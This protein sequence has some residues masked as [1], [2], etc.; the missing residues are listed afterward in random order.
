MKLVKCNQQSKEKGEL[1]K[2]VDRLRA[3]LLS[4]EKREKK[5]HNS[6]LNEIKKKNFFIS[7]QGNEYNNFSM[8]FN[9]II[10]PMVSFPVKK[11][12]GWKHPKL[13]VNISHELV[14]DSKTNTKIS[15][16]DFINTNNTLKEI[17]FN[18]RK[19]TDDIPEDFMPNFPQLKP[20]CG[21][22]IELNHEIIKG[23]DIVGDSHLNKEELERYKN[24]MK[25]ENDLDTRIEVTSKNEDED[26][27]NSNPIERDL[28]IVSITDNNTINKAEL[29]NIGQVPTNKNLRR[30]HT[31]L[32]SI[33][34]IQPK[35]TVERELLMKSLEVI[36]DDPMTQKFQ[37]PH[38]LPSISTKQRKARHFSNRR[39][40]IAHFVY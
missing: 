6:E 8:D 3:N 34:K 37:L 2:M 32:P 5:K 9:G 13:N 22:T 7:S 40:K 21:V 26:K 20:S 1:D 31:R 28:L 14:I 23:P 30:K 16:K 18:E 4:K 12:R 10:L 35:I 19:F 17:Q 25:I 36:K 33:T 24:S 38:R 11:L 15:S 29:K 27:S 39:Y